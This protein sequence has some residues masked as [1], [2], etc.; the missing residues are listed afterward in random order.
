MVNEYRVLVWDIEEVIS[1]VEVGVENGQA[2]GLPA[3]YA[4][5]IGLVAGVVGEQ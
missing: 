2:V 5:L 1:M 4:L 3:L